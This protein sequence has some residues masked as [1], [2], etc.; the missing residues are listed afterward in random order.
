MSH[1]QEGY[2]IVVVGAGPAGMSAAAQFAKNGH[3]VVILNRDCKVGGLAEYGIFPSKHRLR[4]GLQKTY[5]EILSNPHVLYFGNTSVGRDRELTLDELRALGA[6]AIVF[7]TGAQG[8]K[9]IGVE[10]DNAAGVFHAKDVVFHYNQLPGYSERPF[11]VGRRV[12]VIGIGDV[13]IDIAHWLIRYKKVQ[14][15]TAI[16]RRGPAERKYSPK[17]THAVCANIDKDALSREFARIRER[18]EAVGQNPD[19]I[20]ADMVGEFKKPDPPVSGTMM[21]FR[22]LS[23]PRKVLVDAQNRVRALEVENTRLEKKGDDTAAKGT[24]TADEIPCDSV[25]FAVG[26][27]VDHAVGLP[28]KSG[29]FVTNPTPSGNEPDDAWFQAY[30]EASGK[31]VEGVFVAGWARKASEGLVGIAK[32]DGEWCAE[33]VHRYLD[34][35]PTRCASKLD[36]FC[37]RLKTLIDSRQPDVVNKE[38]LQLLAQVEREEAAKSGVEEFKYAT[39]QE[40]LAAIR[41]RRSMVGGRE[42]SPA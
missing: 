9:T 39:N 40:I 30:D 22:F 8:T 27:C 24:G 20:L 38:D 10:G 1:P 41:R 21:K 19:Q 25:I 11:D 15:V 33:V 12:C 7:S 32:R 31:I 14:E 16:V 29:M 17:E 5:R 23:S 2:G 6:D 26:D 42:F 37:G 35:R 3:R 18:L 34:G 4:T 36:E 13:M 28:Y